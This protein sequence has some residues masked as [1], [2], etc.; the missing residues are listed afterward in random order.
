MT[1]LVFPA[2][3]LLLYPV[4][5]FADYGGIMGGTG[6]GW[7]GHMGGFWFLGFGLYAILCLTAVIVFFWLMFRITWAIETI[8]RSEEGKPK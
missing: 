3:A 7:G 8:A 2:M 5:A 1:R 6:M 4:S